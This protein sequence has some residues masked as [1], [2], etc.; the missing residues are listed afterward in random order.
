[1]V[2]TEDGFPTLDVT[3]RDVKPNTPVAL[4]APINVQQAPSPPAVPSVTM[5]KLGDGIWYVNSDGA[6]SWAV[7]FNDYIV[8]VEG[9]GRDARSL[10]VNDAIRKQIPGKPIRYVIN[11]HAHYDHAGGLRTYV[12]QGITIVTQETNRPFFERAWQ[13]PH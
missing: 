6:R 4:S 3:I 12:A 11:T 9:I 1:I 13:R 2:M 7:E 8:A 10:A 5:D